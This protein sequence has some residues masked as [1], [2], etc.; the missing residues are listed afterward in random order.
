M[1]VWTALSTAHDIPCPGC[2]PAFALSSSDVK[3]HAV[4]PSAAAASFA[5]R[6]RWCLSTSQSSTALLSSVVVSWGLPV[7]H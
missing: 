4:M 6:V 1:H 3:Y 5:L 2:R 7:P